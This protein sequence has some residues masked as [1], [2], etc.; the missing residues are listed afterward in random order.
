MGN[1]PLCPGHQMKALYSRTVSATAEKACFLA[2]AWT[3]RAVVSSV[4]SCAKRRAPCSAPLRCKTL[5][6]PDELGH[7]VAP[8]E[9]TPKGHGEDRR[10]HRA[11][12]HFV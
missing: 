1:L 5:S 11:A 10:L 7:R 9:T 3:H 8:Q 12:T 6:T 2:P 4:K